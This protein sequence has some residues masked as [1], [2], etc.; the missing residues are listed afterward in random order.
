[1]FTVA[2]SPA[3]TGTI[4]Y[5]DFVIANSVKKDF[6]YK[7]YLCEE[8][9]AR[10]LEIDHFFPKSHFP[11]QM[12]EW[13]NLFSGC[14]KCN[15]IKSSAFNTSAINQILNCCIEDVE[16][17]VSLRYN[18]ETG[19]IIITSSQ[20]DEKAQ[21]TIDLLNR[22]HNGVGTTSM[23]YFYLQDAIANEL[24]N[25]RKQ[26]DDYS[27]YP[28]EENK[29]KIRKLVSRKASFMAIKRTLISDFNPELIELFD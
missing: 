17:G 23:S 20:Q 29:E 15:K 18:L 14:S 11:E 5:T 1:M 12:H 24:S 6:H 26:I 7:C 25:L 19:T 21:N 13:D 22:I 4:N 8:A 2:K 16:V 3:P 10:H 27:D 9:N 28:S